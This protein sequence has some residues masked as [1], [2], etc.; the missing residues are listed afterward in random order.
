MGSLSRRSSHRH[1]DD[2]KEKDS[3]RSNHRSHRSHRDRSKERDV[4]HRSSR[5][6]SRSPEDDIYRSNHVNGVTQ[7]N[8]ASHVNGVPPTGPKADREKKREEELTHSSHKK[9]ERGED[10]DYDRDRK[11]SKPDHSE[12]FE[13]GD[14][15]RSTKRAHREDTVKSSRK[16]SQAT[17]DM[18]PGKPQP[19]PPPTPKSA[20]NPHELEREARNRER[21]Q[22][23]M[24]RRS[25]A[26]TKSTGP[27]RKMSGVASGGRRVSYKYEDEESSEARTSRVESERE[28]SRWG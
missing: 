19:Q 28:A 5:K 8:G 7:T 3:G 20:P 25:A 12:S 2:D 9:R 18:A 13:N 27:K 23:E 1:R 17:Q 14:N 4:N 24:Q 10:D 21:M 15:H 6:R 16:A 11:R 22:K 26:D